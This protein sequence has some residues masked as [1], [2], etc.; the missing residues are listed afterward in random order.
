MGN[1]IHYGNGVAPE[2]VDLRDYKGVAKTNT[3]PDTFPSTDT[4]IDY[5][6]RTQMTRLVYAMAIVENGSVPLMSDCEQAFNLL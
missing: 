6:N 5:A 3:F 4:V 2:K 1:M